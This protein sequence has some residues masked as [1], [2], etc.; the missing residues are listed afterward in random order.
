MKTELCEEKFMN[1]DMFN[2]E[3]NKLDRF[4]WV[5]QKL[6][7]MIVSTILWIGG[8]QPFDIL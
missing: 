3:E 8:S 5:D 7:L 2:N 6:F 1:Y 4:Y